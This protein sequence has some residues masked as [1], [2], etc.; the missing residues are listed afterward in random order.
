M[1][2]Q[3]FISRSGFDVE[4]TTLTILNEVELKV[5]VWD[6][7]NHIEQHRRPHCNGAIRN[8]SAPFHG[9]STHEKLF[10]VILNPCLDH[11]QLLW[12]QISLKA[13]HHLQ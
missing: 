12:R 3:G 9:N 5:C 2:L 10:F 1:R 8:G 13:G 11:L 7:G 6:D 4:A